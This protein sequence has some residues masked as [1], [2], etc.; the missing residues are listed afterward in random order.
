M[1]F[2]LILQGEPSQKVKKK[3]NEAAKRKK[4]VALSELPAVEGGHEEKN[5]KMARL[6]Q[7]IISLRRKLADE[8]KKKNEI[9]CCKR[10]W[11]KGWGN[12]LCRVCIGNWNTLQTL[13]FESFILKVPKGDENT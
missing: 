7:E 2:S 1:S 4:M 11:S 3:R 10:L 8:K 12:H 13:E 6:E 5:N 9:G